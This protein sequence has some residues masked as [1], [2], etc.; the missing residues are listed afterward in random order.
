[1]ESTC[2]HNQVARK[3]HQQLA[4]KYNLLDSE[5]PYYRYVPD[6]VLESGRALLYWDRPIITDRT[7]VANRPDI[8][9]IDR[10]ERLALIVDVTIPHD[11]NLVKAEN[12]KQIKYLDLAHEIVDMWNVD[13]AIIVPIVV[14]VN[15]L[16]AKSLDQHLRRLA[17]GSWIKSLIQKAVLLD[18][19]RIVRR[20]LSL[21]P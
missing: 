7:I 10:L 9:V 21:R 1:M 19:A 18:M 17:L 3:V 20:F 13:S 15:G 14:S 11:G 2:R 5:V 4:L 16:I 8:V 6:P 12:D